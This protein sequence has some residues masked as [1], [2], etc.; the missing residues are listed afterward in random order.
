MLSYIFMSDGDAYKPVW[1][2][3]TR[4][5]YAHRVHVV[6]TTL[7]VAIARTT[8]NTLLHGANTLSVTGH[9]FLVGV[10]RLL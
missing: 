4:T 5:E 2:R 6:R 8:A 10:T 3:E 1:T 7:S 9:A